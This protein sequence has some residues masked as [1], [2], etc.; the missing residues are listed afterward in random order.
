MTSTRTWNMFLAI[1]ATT[2]TNTFVEDPM[3]A[4]AGLAQLLEDSRQAA[5]AAHDSTRAA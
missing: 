3:A 1:A 2:L 4:L 5:H